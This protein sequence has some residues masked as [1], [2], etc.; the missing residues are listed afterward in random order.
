M[1]YQKLND[2]IGERRTNARRLCVTLLIATWSH[3]HIDGNPRRDGN[4]EIDERRGGCKGKLY[5]LKIAQ[6]EDSKVYFS[7]QN[8]FS[9]LYHFLC[10][11]GHCGHIQVTKVYVLFT[12]F[13]AIVSCLHLLIMIN[14][15][16]II[17]LISVVI[18]ISKGGEVR[19][20]RGAR[21]GE[22]GKGG[23]H[24]GGDTG[25]S[26]YIIIITLPLV[27]LLLVDDAADDHGVS[28]AEG[29]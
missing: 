19:L 7:R 3:R 9:R 22:S 28:D 2:G 11:R 12:S 4:D 1:L 25:R 21:G 6:K 24:N 29:R 16:S 10:H 27:L 15:T 13:F 17:V 18:V 26:R 23:T 5:T 8:T 20:I 14:V